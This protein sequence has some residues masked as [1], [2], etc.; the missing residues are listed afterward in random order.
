MG[1][2]ARGEGNVFLFDLARNLHRRHSNFAAIWSGRSVSRRDPRARAFKYEPKMK[3][4]AKTPPA[5]QVKNIIIF[6]LCMN[7]AGS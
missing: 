4:I 2:E 3:I 1:E 5:T 6:M 7:D